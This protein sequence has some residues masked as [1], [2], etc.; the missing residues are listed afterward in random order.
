MA[1]AKYSAITQNATMCKIAQKWSALFDSTLVMA[2]GLR[3][4]VGVYRSGSRRRNRRR[5]QAG[6]WRAAWVGDDGARRSQRLLV[7]QRTRNLTL[8]RWN[9]DNSMALTVLAR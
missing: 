1:A 7:A 5:V 9:F 4:A 6:A 3:V 8:S 2:N